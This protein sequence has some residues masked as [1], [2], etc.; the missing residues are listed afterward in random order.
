MPTGGYV[1]CT[2]SQLSAVVHMCWS[3][4]INDPRSELGVARHSVKHAGAPSIGLYFA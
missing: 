4:C 1:H 3:E 2:E